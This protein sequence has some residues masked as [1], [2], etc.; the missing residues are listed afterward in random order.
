MTKLLTPKTLVALGVGSI[1]HVLGLIH[2]GDIEASNVSRST[3]PRWVITEEAYRDFL[4]RRSNQ[5]AP[6]PKKST[7]RRPAP[8]REYL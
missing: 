7:P 5:Q 4:D 3:R 8:R 6:P 2:D 1:D